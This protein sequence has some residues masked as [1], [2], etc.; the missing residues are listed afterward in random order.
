LFNVLATR[1]TTRVLALLISGCALLGLAIGSFLNVVIYRVPR[2]QSIVKP[3]S[4]CPNCGAAILERDNIP[5]LSW[6][7]LRG[8]CRNCK[9]PISRRYP[10]VELACSALFAGAAARLGYNWVLPAMLVLMASLL[11]LSCIDVELLLL[12]KLIVYPTLAAVALLLLLDA[13]ISSEWSKLFVAGLCAIGWFVAFFGLNFANPR[14]LGFG[15]VRLALVLGLGLGWFGWRYVVL[16]F[17]AANLI[18]ALIGIA[19]LSTKRM[20]RDQQIP[21][22]VFLAVGAALALYAGPEILSPLQR[23]H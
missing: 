5:V 22:G 13:V 14:Y 9:T 2:H 23:F 3:R 11:A 1:S 12:P 8:L 7:L 15:D 20:S 6:L 4:A 21:Y 17:F 10:L 18:G 16:G 19:L